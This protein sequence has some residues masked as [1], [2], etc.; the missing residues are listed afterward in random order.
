MPIWIGFLQALQQAPGGMQGLDAGLEFRVAACRCHNFI[1]SYS[2][3][4]QPE[5]GGYSEMRHEKLQIINRKWKEDKENMP[6]KNT[7]ISKEIRK[8][9]KIGRVNKNAVIK[10]LFGSG[11]VKEYKIL[12][13]CILMHASVTAGS[14][15]LWWG[16]S[17][18]AGFLCFKKWIYLAFPA[19]NASFR[20]KNQIL[21]L[22]V[23][24]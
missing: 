4:S 22:G 2:R 17:F 21:P 13:F 11:K 18:S 24:S 15:E 12:I 14:T 3:F 7:T 5:L 8:K 1:Q 9:T 16:I 20:G 6:E 10:K 23:L 19:E